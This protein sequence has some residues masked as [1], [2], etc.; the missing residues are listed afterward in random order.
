MVKWVFA[1]GNTDIT[2]SLY[3]VIW[4]EKH[5]KSQILSLKQR[6]GKN[7]LDMIASAP[8]TQ[9]AESTLPITF[10]FY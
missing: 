1:R 6:L 7:P 5:N 10:C 2:T 3:A 8:R 4:L 9:L